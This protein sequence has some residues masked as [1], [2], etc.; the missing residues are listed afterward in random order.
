MFARSGYCE[1][2]H[3]KWYVYTHIY[4][5]SQFFLGVYPDNCLREWS[6]SRVD[7]VVVVVLVLISSFALASTVPDGKPQVTSAHNSSSTSIYLNWKPPPKSSIHGEF[8][9][10]RLAYKPRDDTSPESVQEIFLRDPSIEVCV[11]IF[12]FPTAVFFELTWII[13][14]FG[15]FNLRAMLFKACRRSR[16]TWFRSKC[17]IRKDW[18]QVPP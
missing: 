14:L 8:L 11:Y 5:Y 10:Y 15:R 12:L 7:T 18:G 2:V 6:I 17:L 16:S 3:I 9:G 4:V 1:S 13:W